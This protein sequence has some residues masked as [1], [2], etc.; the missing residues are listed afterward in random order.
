VV[1]PARARSTDPVTGSARDIG[2]KVDVSVPGAPAYRDF[3]VLLADDDPRIGQDFM[4]Y[5][6]NADKNRSGIN[7]RS[8]P[9]GDGS[10]AFSWFSTG[11]IKTPVLQS[12]V[13]D[14]ARVHALVAPGSEQSHVFSLGGLSW[15]EDPHVVGSNAVTAQGV[16][17]WESVEANVVGGAGGEA[18][19]VGDYFYGDLRRPFTQVGVWGWLRSLPTA[20]G[21]TCTAIRPLPGRT[22]G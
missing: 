22:C 8:A 4:P 7:Y 6:T 14:P 16:G 3:T 13:G 9:L 2:A 5:P 19:A 12:Y 10:T 15:P 11:D 20:P 1:S 21:S 18:G 17:P